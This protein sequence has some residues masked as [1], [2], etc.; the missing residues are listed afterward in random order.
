M[1]QHVTITGLADKGRGVGRDETGRVYFIKETA[2]GDVV[3]V[4]VLRKKKSFFEAVVTDYVIRSPHRVNP[5]CADF[6][7]CGGCSFQHIDY[8]LQLAEKQRQVE[9]AFRRIGHIEPGEMQPILGCPETVHFRN[10][11]EFGFSC[12]KWLTR[13]EIA[14]GIPNEQDVLGLHP[15]KAFDKIL[16]LKTCYLQADPSEAIRH[17]CKRIGKEQGLTFYDVMKHEGFLRQLVVRVFTT[18]QVLA[19]VGFGEDDAKKNKDFLDAL[20][21]A[22][23]EITSL[24]YFVNTKMNDFFLDLPITVYDG[25]AQVEEELGHVRFRVGP[26]SFFQTNTRQARRLYDIVLEYAGLTGTEK[27]Y[28]LY[29]GLGSIALYVAGSCASIVGIEEVSAAIDDARENAA[30]NGITNATFYAGDVK[31]VMDGDFIAQYGRPDV[32]ITDPP[33]AG[34]HAD[35]VA[36]IR[37]LGPSRIVYVSCNPSTQARDIALLGDRYRV[38]KTRAVDMFPHTHHVENVA[39]LEKI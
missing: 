4:Q 25:P 10:K 23:P 1:V 33:R 34:M 8:T 16:D 37:T 24:Q 17:A 13:D 5:F 32:L 35:V 20:R 2:P 12:K 14:A 7:F 9:D 15:Q 22:V 30:L 21:R 11:L 18:G 39:L 38:L 27:V 3:N 26:K 31:L 28:D 6:N 36:A 29:T 19:I